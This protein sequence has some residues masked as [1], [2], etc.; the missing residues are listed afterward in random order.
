MIVKVQITEVLQRIIEMDVSNE[1][2]ALD[3]VRDNY[4]LERIVL[5]AEDFVDVNFEVIK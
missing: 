3:I 4:K 2:D 5:N 1:E